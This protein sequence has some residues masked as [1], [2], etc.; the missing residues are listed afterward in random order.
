MR[1][2]GCYAGQLFDLRF[3]TIGSL[4]KGDQGYYIDECLSPGHI[5]EDRGTI[6]DIPRGPF[7]DEEA[8]YV[9]L[10][11]ALRLH[12]EQLPMGYHILRA[13]IPIPQEYGDFAKYHAATDRW[14]D[15]A[16]IGGLVESSANRLQY[17]LANQLLEESMIWNQSL[18]GLRES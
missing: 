6:E 12:A 1:Q 16:T 15:F 7:H 4:L 8:Y 5:F 17:C 13:P 3:P 18:A 11:T 2:L 14:N 10:A 9:S